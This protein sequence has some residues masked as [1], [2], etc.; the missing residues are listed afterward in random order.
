MEAEEKFVEP[1]VANPDRGEVVI[2]LGGKDY[3]C[4]LSIGSVRKLE[5]KLGSLN[6]EKNIPMIKFY[7]ILSTLDASYDEIK[8]VL[9]E[10][11]RGGGMEKVTSEL[12]DELIESEGYMNSY[13][14]ITEALLG[15]LD[16]SGNAEAAF[17][18][19]VNL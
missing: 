5:V 4:R 18:E 1:V 13:K 6:K 2:N 16:V 10:M 19:K 3:V 11:L 12:V 7:T 14:R 17:R 9:I 8:M 15:V